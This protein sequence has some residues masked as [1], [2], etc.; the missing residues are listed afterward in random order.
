MVKKYDTS[1]DYLQS[2]F[3]GN[4]TCDNAWQVGASTS[5]TGTSIS[6][7]VSRVEYYQAGSKYLILRNGNSIYT[8]DGSNNLQLFATLNLLQIYY[9]A[10]G[11]DIYRYTPSTGVT[12]ALPLVPPGMVCLQHSSLNYISSS[13]SIVFGFAENGL[14]GVAEYSL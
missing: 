12:T 6:N 1:N 8:I 11:Y 9:C 4:S 14:Y 13:N 7:N 5:S 3:L 2:H 10:G